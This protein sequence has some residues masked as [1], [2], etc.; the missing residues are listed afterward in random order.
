MK[1]K[2]VNS[3]I[4]QYPIFE[5]PFVLTTDASN[6]A[7]GAILS[8][9]EKGEDLPISYASKTLGKHD[10]NKPVVEKELLAKHGGIEFFRPYL[11]G[12]KFIVVT[13]HRSLI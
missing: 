3:P 2:L 9:E 10:L 6:Y 1:K 12:R 7:L 13:D 8:Q 11:F 5:K 4:L